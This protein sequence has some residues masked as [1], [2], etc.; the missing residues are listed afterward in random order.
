[1]PLQ[2]AAQ[3]TPPAAPAE[4]SVP[5]APSV[6]VTQTTTPTPAVAG[7]T[8]S[9]VYQALRAQR[10]ELINQREAL[11][12]QREELVNQLRRGAMSETDRAGIDQR[13]A[14]LDQQLAAK[15]I[16]LAEVEAQVSVAAGVPGATAEPPRPPS[17]NV[18]EY[19]ARSLFFAGVLL[20]PMAIA[21]SRRIWRRS[22][23]VINLPPELGER[24]E[25]IERS[26]DT[27]AVEVERIGEGQRFV[28]QLMAERAQPSAKLARGADDRHV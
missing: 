16:A 19:F 11:S 8:A 9:Q 2:A 14:L 22:S 23:V 28:T 20:F 3:G 5:A 24:L 4:P 25:S 13:L 21:W 27:V 15:Q 26:V 6:T 18:E 17:D 10:R 7:A 12:G 1:M